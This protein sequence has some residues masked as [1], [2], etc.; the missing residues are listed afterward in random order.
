M[1]GKNYIT[2]AIAALSII[3]LCAAT[4]IIYG[5]YF[6]GSAL[7]KV[8]LLDNIYIAKNTDSEY[9]EKALF[10]TYLAYMGNREYM[11]LPEERMGGVL[12][13]EKNGKKI[14]IPYPKLIRI[15][16]GFIDQSL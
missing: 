4:W 2:I 13:F 9:S 14:F 12:S 11:Y 15:K 7:I 5:I 8:P 16:Q 3:L 10:D 1:F 6:S